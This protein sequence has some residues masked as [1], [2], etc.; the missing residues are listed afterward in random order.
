MS[1]N[2]NEAT[3]LEQVEIIKQRRTAMEIRAQIMFLDYL[4]GFQVQELSKKIETLN[5]QRVKDKLIAELRS[6]SC[7]F[8]EYV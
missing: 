8:I 6:V 2:K 1:V 5:D 4:L 7:A 3:V